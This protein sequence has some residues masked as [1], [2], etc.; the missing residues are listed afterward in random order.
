MAC[1]TGMGMFCESY[2]I[3]SIGECWPNCCCMVIFDSLACYGQPECSVRQLMA[4]N[5]TPIFQTTY[6]DCYKQYITCSESLI[7]SETYIQVHP[8]CSVPLCMPPPLWYLCM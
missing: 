4:G 1:M 5:I 6:K 8:C 7:N 3:F 2:F